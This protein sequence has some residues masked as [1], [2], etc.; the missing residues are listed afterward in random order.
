MKVRA[1]AQVKWI[2]IHK[3][4]YTWFIRIIGYVHGEGCSHS[5]NVC[6]HFY[7]RIRPKVKG[8]KKG[9]PNAQVVGPFPLLNEGW[10]PFIGEWGPP[11][12][13]LR[14]CETFCLLRIASSCSVS[15]ITNNQ[16]H[17]KLKDLCTPTQKRLYMIGHVAYIINSLKTRGL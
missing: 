9:R 15:H 8:K 11:P 1:L 17:L 14:R 4:G 3:I 12:L 13:V 6:L 16:R 10:P 2:T 5:N 7:K